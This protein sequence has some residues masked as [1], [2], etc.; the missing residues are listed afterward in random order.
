MAHLH[1]PELQMPPS[2][3]RKFPYVLVIAL[4]GLIVLAVIFVQT[5][6]P[7]AHFD[8]T[9]E[10]ASADQAPDPTAYEP[11]ERPSSSAVPVGLPAAAY[12]ANGEPRGQGSNGNDDLIKLENRLRAE[13]IDPAWA[14][15]N[16]QA[17]SKAI[18]GSEHDGFDVP[19]PDEVEASCHSSLCS[20]RMT[21]ADEE[22]AAQMQ[23]K[24]ALGLPAA[25]SVARTFNVPRADGVTEIL[26]FAGNQNNLF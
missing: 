24:L 14:A 25:I 4:V 11:A 19:P 26:I 8:T 21:Y 17:I 3:T 1:A 10:L 16:E 2:A 20:I 9:Q 15:A 22:Q 23:L 6:K 12:Q 13:K 7:A 18:V 5:R